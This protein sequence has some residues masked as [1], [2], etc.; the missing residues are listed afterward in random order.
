MLSRDG[1]PTIE[2]LSYSM[3]RRRLDFVAMN[4]S[5]QSQDLPPRCLAG[6]NSRAKM[7]THWADLREAPSR[8][9]ASGPAG[10]TPARQPTG[11][12]RSTTFRAVALTLTRCWRPGGAALRVG[13]SECAAARRVRVRRGGARLDQPALG[14]GE[15]CGS[16]PHSM[17]AVICITTK[18]ETMAPIVIARPVKPWKKKAYEK[19]TR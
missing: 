15:W 9:E 16:S 13:T 18:S 10:E 12:Q 4:A 5:T 11:G 14:T 6:C 7:P 1:R 2:I 19:P 17:R 8:P 3:R